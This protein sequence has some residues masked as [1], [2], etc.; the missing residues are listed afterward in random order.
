GRIKSGRGRIF[1]LN[2]PL[3]EEFLFFVCPAGVFPSAAV[4]VGCCSF[5]ER[6]IRVPQNVCVQACSRFAARCSYRLFLRRR[7]FRSA[8]QLVN[9]LPPC[10]TAL[11]RDRRVLTERDCCGEG[12]SRNSQKDSHKYLGHR[13]R[14]QPP[15]L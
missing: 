8:T 6:N 1:T 7:K 9:V 14:Q 13:R 11:L 10:C 12:K 15:E 5:L 2:G 3:Q 4:L